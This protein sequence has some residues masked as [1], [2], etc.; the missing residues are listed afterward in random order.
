MDLGLAGK[1][2]LVQGASAGLG[3]AVARELSREGCLVSLCSRDAGR[4]RTAAEEIERETGRTVAGFAC[5]V[6][7]T[8][9][10]ARH[11]EATVE[12]FGGLHVLLC[13]AGGPPR[14]RFE[15]T[16][17]E[18][19]NDAVRANFLSVVDTCRLVVPHMRKAGW[20]RILIVTSIAVKQPID[21]LVLSNATRAGATG[22]AKSLA[23]EVGKDGITVNCLCPGVTRTGRLDSLVAAAKAQGQTEVQALESLS[24]GVPV[25][26]VGTPEE[27]A[28][29]AAFLASERASYVTGTSIAIDGGAARGLL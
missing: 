5:D 14:K 18:E 1:V 22:F 7:D 8:T 6:R 23:N 17:P 3:R 16:T 24:S 27:F 9:A 28:A 2:A 15:E 21:G 4:A 11:V 29:V 20:G 19:W 26:R 10:L 12:R 13:N 25:G